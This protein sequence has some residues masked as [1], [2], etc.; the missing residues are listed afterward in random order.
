MHC[1]S[2][3]RKPINNGQVVLQKMSLATV[4]TRF[5]FLFRDSVLSSSV[6]RIHVTSS[7]LSTQTT[8]ELAL[9]VVVMKLP[10]YKVYYSAL[11]RPIF[12]SLARCVDPISIASSGFR[13]VHETSTYHVTIISLMEFQFAHVF[14]TLFPLAHH[15]ACITKCLAKQ[16]HPLIAQSLVAQRVLKIYLSRISPR[17]PL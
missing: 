8:Q 16:L 2:L 4:R 6:A 14:L 9:F 10:A 5:T 1:A 17:R 12:F 3:N 7:R 15:I 11:F 13:S